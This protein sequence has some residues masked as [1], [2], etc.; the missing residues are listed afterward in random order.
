MAMTALKCD[1]KDIINNKEIISKIDINRYVSDKV[2]IPTLKDIID[3]LE[4]P[5]RDPRIQK[6]TINIENSISDIQQLY[7]GMELNGIV[8]NITDFGCFVDIG[9]KE[10]GLVHISQITDKFI[11]DPHSIVSINQRVSVKV[12]DVDIQRKRIQL[13]MK[14]VNQK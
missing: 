12:M 13:T 2:G 3:E 10:K 8:T 5:G 11:K 9:I 7:T 4:K 6:M 1:I 14:G